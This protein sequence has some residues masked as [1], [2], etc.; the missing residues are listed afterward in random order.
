MFIYLSNTSVFLLWIALIFFAHFSTELLVVF[1]ICV[2]FFINSGYKSFLIICI[3]SIFL[4]SMPHLSALYMMSSVEH[5]NFN[6]VRFTCP[7]LYSLCFLTL[8]AFLLRWFSF[9]FYSQSLKVFL[10]TIRTLLLN[11]VWGRD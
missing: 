5:I 6:V 11:M 4:Q 9:V 10:F 2:K 1:L 3:A 7:F 8:I